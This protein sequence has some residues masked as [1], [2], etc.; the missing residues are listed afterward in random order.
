M[1]VLITGVSGFVGQYL[2]SELHAN[3]YEVV[4]VGKTPR[5]NIVVCDVLNRE[6][7][8]S[9]IKDINPD[10]VVHLAGQTR[11]HDSWNNPAKTMQ[12]NTL[13]SINVLDAV[14]YLNKEVRLLFIGSSE[15]YGM[16]SAENKFVD[17]NIPTKPVNPYGISKQA[18][19]D[20]ILSLAHKRNMDVVLTR[21]FN[22]IGPGQKIGM[23]IP[24]FA[25]SIV[26]IEKHIQEPIIRVGNLNLK[27][28][29]TDVRDVVKA[30]LLL[31]KY[32][33]SG[34]IYNVGNGK[35]YLIRSLLD[36]M[37]ELSEMEITIEIDV[38][39]FRPID[40]PE[41]ICNNKKIYEHCNWLPKIDIK[42]TLEETV[43]YWRN[44][45]S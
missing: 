20:L 32:G 4:G 14:S 30:Y 36:Y 1:K 8:L 12:L 13:S 28:D 33:H 3:N 37:I 39:K 24:D 42:K 10:A 22:H 9:V 15:Q 35:S 29:F 21:S 27:R 43:H 45:S 34:E 26:K 41:L 2:E 31:I 5:K 16:I 19:E 11:V 7:L 25:S 18:Q 40:I 23:V 38:N 44:L 6:R 17:E